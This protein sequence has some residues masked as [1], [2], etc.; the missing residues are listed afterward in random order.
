MTIKSDKNSIRF[1]IGEETVIE[2][3]PGDLLVN[4]ESKVRD[5]EGIYP[6]DLYSAFKAYQEMCAERKALNN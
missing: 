6:C 3:T 4:K 1:V 2:I 5:H